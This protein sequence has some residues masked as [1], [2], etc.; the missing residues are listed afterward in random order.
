MEIV[1]AM[2]VTEAVV[3]AV[4]DTAIKAAEDKVAAD[5]AVAEATQTVVKVDAKAVVTVAETKAHAKAVA[6]MVAADKEADIKAAK[7]V[8][9]GA[10]TKVARAVVKVA[11]V[12]VAAVV[13]TTAVAVAAADTAAAIADNPEAD[14]SL[15]NALKVD[16]AAATTPADAMATQE[17]DEMTNAKNA[18]AI[19]SRISLKRTTSYSSSTNLPAPQPAKANPQPWLTWSRNFQALASG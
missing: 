7:A 12:M 3:K 14:H 10:D 4:A 16:P 1:E 17:T 13:E 18:Y 11:A 5:T 2:A 15:D 9:K 8:V 6:D 19:P